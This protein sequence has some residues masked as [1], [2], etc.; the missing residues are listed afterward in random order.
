MTLARPICGYQTPSSS[1]SSTYVANGTDFAI[2]YGSS[3]VAGVKIG[4]VLG[5]VC[6]I[7]IVVVPLWQNFFDFKDMWRN[8]EDVKERIATRWWDPTPVQA[9]E[10]CWHVGPSWHDGFC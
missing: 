8:W 3:N 10:D 2:Q 6:W 5:I 4:T 1:T 9:L 7:S